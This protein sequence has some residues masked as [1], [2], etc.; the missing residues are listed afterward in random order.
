MLNGSEVDFGGKKSTSDFLK[1]PEGRVLMHQMNAKK[2]CGLLGRLKSQPVSNLY[3][4]LVVCLFG[5]VAVAANLAVQHIPLGSLWAAGTQAQELAAISA[6]ALV[7]CLAGGALIL[8]ALVQKKKGGV[9]PDG[10]TLEFFPVVGAV[11]T[12]PG[13]FCRWVSAL[14]D[15]AV[16]CSQKENSY[17][18]GGPQPGR[19]RPDTVWIVRCTDFAGQDDGASASDEWLRDRD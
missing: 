16:P 4:G 8:T 1:K 12:D 11:H 15:R 6:L 7:L 9:N 18:A 10:G 19:C 5:S 3:M 17:H 2:R 14:D 13:S